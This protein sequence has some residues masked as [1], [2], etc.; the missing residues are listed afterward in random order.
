MCPAFSDP[1][2]KAHVSILHGVAG[3]V[4]RS[5]TACNCGSGSFSG[6]GNLGRIPTQPQNYSGFN[7]GYGSGSGSTA[8]TEME[9]DHGVFYDSQQEADRLMI[10]MK[11]MKKTIVEEDHEGEAEVEILR[12]KGGEARSSKKEEKGIVPPWPK[13]TQRST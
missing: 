4:P 5:T 11:R 7:H 12:Q 8:D 2:I 3:S 9:V 13:I 6:G 1:V 10:A